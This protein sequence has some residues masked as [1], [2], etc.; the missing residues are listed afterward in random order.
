MA[1]EKKFIKK[2]LNDFAVTE[3]LKC[4]LEKAG[5]SS[6]STTKTPLATRIAIH[7]RKPGIVV[8][9]KG[10][11]I[12]E[13]AETLEKKYGVENPQIEVIEVM[14]PTLDAQLMA[15]KI[16]KQIELRGNIKQVMRFA[17]KDMMDAGAIGAEI[18]VAGKV[19]GKGGKAKA[20]AVRA[21]YLRKAGKETEKVQVGRY[22]A[23]LKAGAIGVTV[24]LVPPGTVFSDQISASSIKEEELAA[25]QPKPVEQALQPKN[26]EAVIEQKIEE[27]KK[28]KTKTAR[29]KRA[30]AKKQEKPEEAKES[31]KEKKEE[32]SEA[33]K[34]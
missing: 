25:P 30:P 7:V 19:V 3:F 20:L 2:A 27:A 23:Y 6:I 12:R 32:K 16:G 14:N 29:R 9:K 15:E 4:E 5:V 33:A 31:E 10:V 8:G 1:S 22:T 26:E 34:S 17:L 11:T 13:L 24:R 18:R 21:G 28:E